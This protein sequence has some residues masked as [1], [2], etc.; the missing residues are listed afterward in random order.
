[1]S[2]YPWKNKLL[3]FCL[4]MLA[5]TVLYIY[6]NFRPPF[7]PFYLPLFAIDQAV[8]LIPWTF[9]VYTSD[10]LLVLA[11]IIMIQDAEAFRAFSRKCFEVLIL[12]G[13]FFI[14]FPTRYPRP[15]Y[16][17]VSNP[18]IAFVMGLINVA[19][20]PLNCFP[21]MHVALT[22]V[23]AWCVRN[24]SPKVVFLFTLWSL[25]IFA[26]TMTTKQHYFLDIVGG[27]GVIITVLLF[28]WAFFET[29]HFRNWLASRKEMA[30]KLLKPR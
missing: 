21:S 3:M 1:M 8:P 22:G 17:E 7:P 25:A 27:V 11:V 23:S 18:L 20:T 16:P 13:V 19:D 24:R 12:C 5:Y 28:D 10:Y 2:P 9:L 6:P 29:P 14:F 30:E 26:S 4:F 15:G